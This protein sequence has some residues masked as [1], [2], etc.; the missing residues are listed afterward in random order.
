MNKKCNKCGVEL[1]EENTCKS[2]GMCKNDCT[3]ENQKDCKSC[4]CKCN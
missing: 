4:N 2:C 3:C 1:T